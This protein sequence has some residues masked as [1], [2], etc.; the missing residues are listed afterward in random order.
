[1]W[2]ARRGHRW[3][4]FKMSHLENHTVP[5]AGS[6]SK[7]FLRNRGR[8][9]PN[10]IAL[11]ALPLSVDAL[12][13]GVIPFGAAVEFQINR[14]FQLAWSTNASQ[15]MRMWSPKVSSAMPAGRI[16][17]KPH[18]ARSRSSPWQKEVAA[19]LR[20]EAW[21]TV[22]I[23]SHIIASGQGAPTSAGQPCVAYFW[24]N[25]VAGWG[26]HVGG[27]DSVWC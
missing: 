14:G 12:T 9:A 11:G 1:M 5:S 24:S 3:N 6:A 19:G 17:L 4:A 13:E 15:E 27:A 18:S 2:A 26:V 20:L 7:I 10:W 16:M 25:A 22:S 21:G 8:H 23:T